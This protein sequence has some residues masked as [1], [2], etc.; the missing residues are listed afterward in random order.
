MERRLPFILIAAGIAIFLASFL[1]FAAPKACAAEVANNSLDKIVTLYRDKASSWETALRNYALTLFFLLA[2]I[3]F[4]VSVIRL[5]IRGSD[6]SEW[7]AEL[8]N[9][10]LF[11]GFFLAL[12]NNSSAWARAI[13]NSFRAA[14]N[15]AANSAADR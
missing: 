11:L 14:A 9:Q 15:Q 5:A 6:A 3:E 7:L 2:T 1:F 13:V 8:V 10:V 12:L 4:V